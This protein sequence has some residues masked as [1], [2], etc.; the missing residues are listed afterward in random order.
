ME[1]KNIINSI[2]KYINVLRTKNTLRYIKTD[3]G[4]WNPHNEKL[5]IDKKIDFANYDNCF[6]SKLFN[7]AT[8][9]TSTK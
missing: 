9:V 7:N 5:S 1:R 8:P 3:L 6:T 2:F 4:R